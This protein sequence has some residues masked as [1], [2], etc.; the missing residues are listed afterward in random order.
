MP[1]ADPVPTSSPAT[2]PVAVARAATQSVYAGRVSAFGDSVMLGARSTLATRLHARVFAHE[3]R[4][5]GAVLALVRAQLRTGKIQGPVVIH[6]GTNGTISKA[7]LK[8]TVRAVQGRHLVVL[9]NV[10][11]PARYSWTASNNRILAQVAR[12]FPHV[13]QLDWQRLASR[14]AGWFWPDR[15]HL[16]QAGAAGYADAIAALLRR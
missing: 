12:A 9:V 16:R 1:T 6:V 4:Q 7:D 15:I 13:V 3:S 5:A 11:L 14:H 8:Q 2:S 10:K